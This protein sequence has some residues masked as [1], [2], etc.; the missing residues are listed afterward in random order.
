M[1]NVCTELSAAQLKI[2][3]ADNLSNQNRRFFLYNDISKDVCPF[4][5]PNM[6][7]GGLLHR[8]YFCI[9]TL[10]QVAAQ[11]IFH[12]VAAGDGA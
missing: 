3:F 11:H 7:S 2:F 1:G 8:I 4:C 12:L 9:L 6:Q 5:N 10:T